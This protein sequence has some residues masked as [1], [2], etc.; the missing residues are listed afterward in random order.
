MAEA[1]KPKGFINERVHTI[2]A[3]G[4][5]G[6]V[7]VPVMMTDV[8]L[9]TYLT[10]AQKR[11]DEINNW[12][13]GDPVVMKINTL[14]DS[15]KHLVREIDFPGTTLALFRNGTRPYP[16]LVHVI[17]PLLEPLVDDAL[18]LPNS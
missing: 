6:T 5:K 2:E 12:E 15:R 3:A 18:N 9:A 4:L 8:D 13:E 7:T 11:I 16:A 17:L 10:E 1:K 14:F